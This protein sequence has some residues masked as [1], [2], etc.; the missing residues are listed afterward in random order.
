MAVLWFYRAVQSFWG[1]GV[2]QNKIVCGFPTLVLGPIQLAW[3][4]VFVNDG[5]VVIISLIVNV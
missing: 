1:T 3:I 5:T 2:T 4:R